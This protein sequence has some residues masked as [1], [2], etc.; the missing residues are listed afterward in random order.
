MALYDSMYLIPVD[1]Y[2]QLVTKASHAAQ[3]QKQAEQSVSSSKADAMSI[4]DASIS[5]EGVVPPSVSRRSQ[6]AQS[7]TQ[8]TMPLTIAPSI[9]LR[10]QTLSH[11]TQSTPSS[12][13]ST[14]LAKRTARQRRSRDVLLQQRRTVPSHVQ[15]GPPI[16]SRQTPV[17]VQQSRLH[18]SQTEQLQDLIQQRLEQLQGKRT[19]RRERRKMEVMT[20]DKLPEAVARVEPHQ[21]T[22]AV[23]ELRQVEEVQQLPQTEEVQVQ[24]LPQTEEIQVPLVD[25]ETQ[26]SLSDD[27]QTGEVMPVTVS[28]QTSRKRQYETDELLPASQRVRFEAAPLPE[29]KST[30]D[31]ITAVSR[32]SR[33]RRFEANDSDFS[34]AQRSRYADVSDTHF[35]QPSMT[36][37]PASIPQQSMTETERRDGQEIPTLSAVQA[38]SD[39]PESR[40]GVVAGKKRAAVQEEEEYGQKKRFRPLQMGVVAGVKRRAQRNGESER[41]SKVGRVNGNYPMW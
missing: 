36:E 12:L 3:S 30:Q 39:I 24:Q 14:Q 31:Y 9:Q 22:L 34:T 5:Q 37:L 6:A 16:Q 17:Q 10:P 19:K 38:S 40:S 4:A 32:P 33:K 28:M 35:T 7:T 29:V 25:A 15:R 18:P 13:Q 41:S 11:V 27:E 23:D 2:N 21:P 8:P 26:V 1:S 20:S